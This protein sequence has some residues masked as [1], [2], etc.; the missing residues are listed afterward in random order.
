MLKIK[1]EVCSH[2]LQRDHIML[3]MFDEH[4]TN[5]LDPC[6]ISVHVL[7]FFEFD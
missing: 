5:I 2:L 3:R 1:E 6:P 4:T 7:L